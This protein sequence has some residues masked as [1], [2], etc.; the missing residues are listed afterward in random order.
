MLGKRYNPIVKLWNVP[1]IRVLTSEFSVV[2][3]GP[4]TLA[5]SDE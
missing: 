4:P 3:T 2:I 5:G 1:L